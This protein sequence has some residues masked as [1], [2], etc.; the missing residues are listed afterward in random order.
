MNEECRTERKY[1][2]DGEGNVREEKR[3]RGWCDEE[4]VGMYLENM[5]MMIEVDAMTR[6][7]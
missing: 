4:M 3:F 7:S 6:D 5:V 2:G 1:V